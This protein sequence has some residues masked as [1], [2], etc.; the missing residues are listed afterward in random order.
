V[1]VQDAT[2]RAAIG[3]ADE[4]P[5]PLVDPAPDVGPAPVGADGAGELAPA[6]DLLDGLLRVALAEAERR[7]GAGAAADPYRGLYLLPD[8]VEQSLTWARGQPMFP[9]ALPGG[10]TALG[11]A[12]PRLVKLTS[13]L[14]LTPF[15]AALLVV[16][17]APDLDLRYERIYAILQDD[18]TRRRP[19]LDLTLNLLCTSAAE[20]L[21]R[22]RHVT[23]DAP[24]V[25]TGL[26]ELAADPARHDPPLL[27]LELAL[28]R[29]ASGF[30]VGAPGPDPSLAPLL[31]APPSPDAFATLPA[32]ARARVTRA[33]RE[34]AASATPLRLYFRGADGTGRHAAARLL[35]RSA[36]TS[37]LALD[38]SRA[39]VDEHVLDRLLR[40]AFLEARLRGWL[41]Y[42]AG[43]DAVPARWGDAAAGRLLAAVAR[44]PGI[45]LL[46]GTSEWWATDGELRDV[47]TVEFGPAPFRRRRAAWRLALVAAGVEVDP[48][49]TASLAERFELTPLQVAAAARVASG[50]GPDLHRALFAAARAQAGRQLGEQARRVEP[51][52]RF[53]DLV[54]PA[55]SKRQLVEICRRVEHRRLVLDEWG[56]GARLPLGSGVNVLFSGPSG[57]GKTMAA[58]VVAGALGLDLYRIDLSR[59]VSKYIGETEKNL[60]RIFDQAEASN[61]ILFFDE[62]DALFG[63]RSEV[64]DAHDRYANIEIGYLLQKMEEYRG[65]TILATNLRQNMDEAFVRR[66]AFHVHFAMPDE[67]DRIR[68]WQGVL[69][70]ELP[71][72]GDVDAEFLGGRFKV[73]GGN[74]RNAALAGAFLAADEGVPLAMRHLVLGMRREFQKMGK[75]CVEADFEPYFHLLDAAEP[76]RGGAT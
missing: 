54:L 6:L 19:S 25:R 41:V 55:D 75:A 59:V 70:Q 46:S 38:L 26:L 36:D 2:L 37:L 3:D 22:R 32:P 53:D 76:Q 20:K 44:H 73:S 64:K 66:L 51:V 47:A 11:T 69:P 17:V 33:V 35:A 1:P 7:F 61:A 30:L 49:L 71:V 16:A 8:D 15:D 21:E 42:V 62:A 60:G 45:V 67:R 14:V 58:Q 23:P 31:L 63:K 72:D 34:A 24:L 12:S 48:A 18:V 74:I 43:A 52:F 39:D 13:D 29:P 28:A 57:T 68:I 56:F 65:V 50:T 4:E 5:L 27:L 40:Y 10:A 9:P